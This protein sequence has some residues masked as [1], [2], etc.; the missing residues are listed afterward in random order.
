M[1]VVV[2]PGC[3]S[4]LMQIHCFRWHLFL[5]ELLEMKAERSLRPR[6]ISGAS[7]YL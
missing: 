6:Y 1:F 7:G 2:V 4:G 5:Y 3:V